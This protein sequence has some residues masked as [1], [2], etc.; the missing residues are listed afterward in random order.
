MHNLLG[1]FEEAI[2]ITP[3]SKYVDSNGAKIHYL[4]W[5]E[6][7][8]PGLF[9]IH[10]YSAHAHWWDFI[11]PSFLEDYCVVAIDL[12]GM[13]DSEHRNSY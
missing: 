12:S 10:G 11:A 3:E 7:T 6:T 1:W 8:N 13:G 2:K 5:G 9:L 4:V